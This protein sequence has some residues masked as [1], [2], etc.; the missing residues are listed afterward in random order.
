MEANALDARSARQR[1]QARLVGQTSLH[2]RR[3]IARS[4]ADFVVSLQRCCARTRARTS[5]REAG[6]SVL[7]QLR[8]T[9]KHFSGCPGQ[10][11]E[12]PKRILPT[13]SRSAKS[14]QGAPAQNPAI[15][16][17]ARASTTRSGG[18]ATM[19]SSP[20]RGRSQPPTA[21]GERAGDGSK[22]RARRRGVGTRAARAP[23]QRSTYPPPP[24]RPAP[25]TPRPRLLR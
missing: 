6:G 14:P 9:A 11:T 12:V 4:R 16:L 25:L 20:V 21:S 1:I 8:A 23:R 22:I 17:A 2:R 15:R 19:S 10:I 24:I 13:P 18:R 3:A 7:A 5:A